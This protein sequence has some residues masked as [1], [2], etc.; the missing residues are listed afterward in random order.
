MSD[1]ASLKLKWI[2]TELKQCCE[3]YEKAYAQK[4]QTLNEAE[5][6]ALN[7]TLEQLEREIAR[8]E[9]QRRQL[10]SND[11]PPKQPEEPKLIASPKKRG[12]PWLTVLSLLLTLGSVYSLALWQPWQYFPKPEPTPTAAAVVVPTATPEPTAA[13]TKPSEPTA[14]PTPAEPQA[15]EVWT[16]PTTGMAFVYVP[17]GCFQMGQTDTQ[18]AQLVA[19][20]GEENYQKWYADETQ[21]NVC[22]RKMDGFWM[23]KYEVA[24]AQYRQFKA[25][26][27]SQDYEGKSLND[28]TQPVVYVSWNDAV[29]FTEWLTKQSGGT[30]EFRLPTEAEWE[31][32]ARA[33]TETVRYWGDDPKHTQACQYENVRDQA[34]EKEF[35]WADN[36]DCNDGYAVTAPVGTFKPN[37]FGLY[38]MLGNVWEWCLDSYASYSETPTDGSAYGNL[39]DGKA[40]ILRGGSWG[41]QPYLVR[42]SGRSRY[43]PVFQH[44]SVGFRVVVVR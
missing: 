28:D 32:A 3:K 19:D 21:H 37:K 35:S 29:A 41:N 16:E 11:P 40:K 10:A 7:A 2:E 5:K 43:I 44:Y 39:E 6:I 25:D 14:T 33:G 8:L 20:V 26:H 30:A 17:G 36:H 4:L 13:P 34:S 15:G 42:S 23:G 9:E 27:D 24:N 22:V 18:K 12:V 31:Y 1:I 38:D